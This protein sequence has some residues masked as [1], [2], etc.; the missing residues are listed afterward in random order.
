M[1]K[2]CKNRLLALCLGT[3][4]VFF[5]QSMLCF[6]EHAGL[7]QCPTEQQH[8][9]AGSSDEKGQT[10]PS[11]CCHTHSQGALVVVD[12]AGFPIGD[13]FTDLCV[14][15]DDAAPDGPVREIDLPPQLS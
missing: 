10:T 7:V 12:S 9:N 3:V 4:F 5:A 6:A 15:P 2:T 1:T 14:K 8:Q 11:H 13:L